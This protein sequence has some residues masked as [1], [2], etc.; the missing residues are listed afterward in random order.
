MACLL[1]LFVKAR[2]ATR[3]DGSLDYLRIRHVCAVVTAGD[4]FH[5]DE[6]DPRKIGVLKIYII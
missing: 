3:P 4:F 2:D 1:N 5:A 6:F